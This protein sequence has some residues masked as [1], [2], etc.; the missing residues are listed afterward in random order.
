MEDE[1]NLKIGTSNEAYW[2]EVKEKTEADI[3]NLNKLLMFQA[4]ILDMAEAK[5]KEEHDKEHTTG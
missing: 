5:I 3:E 2:T 1:L 4:A